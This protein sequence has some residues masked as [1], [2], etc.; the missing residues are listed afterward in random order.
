MKFECECD[1]DGPTCS[2]RRAPPPGESTMRP[3]HDA[4]QGRKRDGEG[5]NEHGGPRPAEKMG[6]V[7]RMMVVLLVV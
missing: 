3:K 5:T 6:K 1:E 4:R 2:Q 7:V